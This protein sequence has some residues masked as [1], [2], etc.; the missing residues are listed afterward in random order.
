[1]PIFIKLADIAS[2]DASVIRSGLSVR[3]CAF[4]AIVNAE[5]VMPRDSFE[6]LLPV[7]GEII[8]ASSGRLGP[9]GSASAIVWMASLPQRD[10]TRLTNS[11]ASQKRVSVEYARSLKMGRTSSPDSTSL[12]SAASD[13]E[14]EQKEADIA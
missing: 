5:S 12:S 7:Q 11:D 2:F 13:A 4:A 8:S 6:R 3:R 14:K 9:R 1:M 10:S